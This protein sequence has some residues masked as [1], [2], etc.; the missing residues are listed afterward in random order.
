MNN[1]IAS[2]TSGI[3]MTSVNGADGISGL[4]RGA[5][6]LGDTQLTP[7]WFSAQALDDGRAITA[8]SFD[9]S[10]SNASVDDAAQQIFARLFPS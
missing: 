2:G 9:S 3:H 6:G 7:D 1:S 4:A 5:R 10:Q 8:A